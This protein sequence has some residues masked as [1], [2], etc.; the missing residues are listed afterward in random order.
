MIPIV[1]AVD[2][3]DPRLAKDGTFAFC[4]GAVTAAGPSAT[5]FGAGRC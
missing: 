5:G 1:L 4:G 2:M 3:Y